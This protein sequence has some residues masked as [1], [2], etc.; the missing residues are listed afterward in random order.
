MIRSN[1]RSTQSQA[2]VESFHFENGEVANQVTLF[3]HAQHTQRIVFV[4]NWKAKQKHWIEFVTTLNQ[5]Y[6]VEY[7]ESREKLNTRYHVERVDMRIEKMASDLANYLNQN[8]TPYHLV[9]TSIGSCTI[10]KAWHMLEHKPQSLTLICPVT[11][12]KLPLYFRLFPLVNERM[13]RLVAPHVFKLLASSRQLKVV[14]S[15]LHQSFKEKDLRQLMSMKRSVEDLLKMRVGLH[16]YEA[17]Q[18]PR[19]VIYT[20]KDRIH[21]RKD[22]LKI[23]SSM[24][25]PQQLEFPDFR[26]VHR[27]SSAEAILDWLVST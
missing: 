20:R 9:G 1:Y 2:E 15:N 21:L 14:S 16:E 7:F 23:A 17:I 5:H 22:A 3:Q 12:F 26:A 27:R 24:S 10:A 25:V 4:P 11:R 19:L 13:A 6:N 18:C 8:K